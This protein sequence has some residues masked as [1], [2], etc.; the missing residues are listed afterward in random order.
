MSSVPG[1]QDLLVKDTPGT[2]VDWWTVGL[3]SKVPKHLQTFPL[4]FLEFS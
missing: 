2:I 1:L 4:V 3:F